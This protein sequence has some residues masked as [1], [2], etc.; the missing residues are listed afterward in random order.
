MIQPPHTPLSLWLPFWRKLGTP[1]SLSAVGTAQVDAFLNQSLPPG[2][3]L[4]TSASL[5]LFSS[6]G[7]LVQI[8]MAQ[9][10]AQ[11]PC[12]AIDIE[13]GGCKLPMSE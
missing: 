12:T 10:A 3:R 8:S 5:F 1:L 2:I 6:A 4:A 13:R 9:A 7:F 11:D